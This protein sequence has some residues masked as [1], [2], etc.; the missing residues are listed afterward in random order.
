[1]ETKNM[2]KR[3]AIAQINLLRNNKRIKICDKKT[4]KLM[5][6]AQFDEKFPFFFNIAPIGLII[7]NMQGDILTRTKTILDLLGYHLK[8]LIKMNVTSLYEDPNDRKHLL[9]FCTL[10]IIF[11]SLKQK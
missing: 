2:N 5:R 4:K 3:A 11:L 6:P 7:S 8:F 1:M 9:V 10:K